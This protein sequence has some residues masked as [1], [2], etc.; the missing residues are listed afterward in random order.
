MHSMSAACVS[1]SVES[2]V[3][4]VVF[5]YETRQ[6]KSRTLSDDRANYEMQIGYNGPDLAKADTMLKK[7]MDSYFITS[8]PINKENGISLLTQIG[9]SILCQKL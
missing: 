8:K 6:T 9:L 5:I 2:I 4:S 3:E 1:I 7:A